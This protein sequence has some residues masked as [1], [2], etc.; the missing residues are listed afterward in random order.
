MAL[1]KVPLSEAKNLPLGFDVS[2]ELLEMGRAS[3]E[4]SLRE[5]GWK[6]SPQKKPIAASASQN[7]PVKQPVNSSILKKGD[8]VEYLKPVQGMG[9][10]R[11]Q[12]EVITELSAGYLVKWDNGSNQRVSAEY[13]KLIR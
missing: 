10:K 9:G 13:L 1:K 5:H 2:T 4:S 7:T 3:L 12:G 6:G 11:L 8:R